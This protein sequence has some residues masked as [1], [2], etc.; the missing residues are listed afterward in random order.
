MQWPVPLQGEGMQQQV[1]KR[2]FEGFVMSTSGGNASDKKR[3]AELITQGGGIYSKDLTRACTHLLIKPA[4]KT[5][6]K[7]SDKEK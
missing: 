4:T 2:P 7:L 3:L 6:P 1:A 5:G